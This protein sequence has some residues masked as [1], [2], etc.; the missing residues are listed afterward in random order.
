MF[1]KVIFMSFPTSLQDLEEFVD[2][3]G[4]D[5]FIVFTLGSMVSNMPE[6]IAKQFFDAFRQIPQRVKVKI[7]DHCT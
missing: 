4:A 7:I 6:E 5:G 3:S 1:L 2:G